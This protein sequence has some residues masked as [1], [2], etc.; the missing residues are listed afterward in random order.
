MLCQMFSVSTTLLQPSGSPNL[1]VAA[2]VTRFKARVCGC[3]C[4]ELFRLS[5][6][7]RPSKFFTQLIRHHRT[8]SSTHWTKTHVDIVKSIQPQSPSTDGDGLRVHSSVSGIKQ[9]RFQQ[10]RLACEHKSINVVSTSTSLLYNKRCPFIAEAQQGG[11]L[12]AIRASVN[13]GNQ[14]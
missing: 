2:R 8:S 11:V 10:A 5:V 12:L 3:G 13:A 9:F 7:S 14:R 1:P 6:T 4:T